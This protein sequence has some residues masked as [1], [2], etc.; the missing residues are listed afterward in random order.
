MVHSEVRH[1]REGFPTL[2]TLEGLLS[3]VDPVMDSEIRHLGEAFPTLVT[4]VGFFSRV[5]ALVSVEG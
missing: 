3:R 5:R 4:L 1:P 2:V